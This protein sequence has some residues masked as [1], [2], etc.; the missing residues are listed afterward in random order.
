MLA[1]QTQCLP[2]PHRYHPCSALRLIMC[3][4]CNGTAGLQV[5]CAAVSHD[6]NCILAACTDSCLRLL[7]RTEGMLLHEYRGRC[8]ARGRGPTALSGCSSLVIVQ[9]GMGS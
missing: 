5:T 3:S 7:D 6:G 1:Q 2:G 4:S 9:A 8:W